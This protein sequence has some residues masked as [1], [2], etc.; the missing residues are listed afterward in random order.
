MAKVKVDGEEYV[1]KT[2]RAGER[3]VIIVVDNRGLTFVGRGDP[4]SDGETMTI[5]DARC[6]IRWGTSHHLAE[7]IDGPKENTKLGAKGDVNINDFIIFYDADEKGWKDH[8]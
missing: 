8:V 2:K 7:L 1:K 5:K 4:K 3:L 6:L